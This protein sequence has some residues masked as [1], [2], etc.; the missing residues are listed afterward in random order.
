M[1]K[2]HILILLIF[3]IVHISSAMASTDLSVCDIHRTGDDLS[4][5]VLNNGSNTTARLTVYAAVENDALVESLHPYPAEGVHHCNETWNITHPGAVRMRIH[6]AEIGLFCGKRYEKNVDHLIIEDENGILVRDYHGSPVGRGADP[7]EYY[8]SDIYTPWVSGGVIRIILNIT[9]E[10]WDWHKTYGFRIDEYD[11]YESGVPIY[12]ED[13]NF[14]DHELK[15]ILFPA[16]SDYVV[17]IIDEENNINETNET[18]NE[19]TRK[20]APEI[21]E[22]EFD[23]A[24][25]MIGDTVTI[26]A[27]VRNPG[28]DATTKVL[29][30]IDDADVA[31]TTLSIAHNETG[32]AVFHWTATEG[33]HNITIVTGDDELDDMLCV[34]H[35]DLSV[36]N[37]TIEPEDPVMGNPATITTDGVGDILVYDRGTVP[38]HL[39]YQTSMPSSASHCWTLRHPGADWI[40]LH[41]SH[42]KLL[43]DTRLTISNGT[44]TESYGYYEAYTNN[45]TDILTP[46]IGGD[47]LYICLNTTHFANLTIDKYEYRANEPLPSNWSAYP[48]GPHNITAVVNENESIPELD[49]TNNRLSKEIIVEGCD[50][51]ITHIDITPE[52]S[53]RD[54]ETVEI[55]VTVRNIGVLPATSDVSFLVDNKHIDFRKITL[56]EGESTTLTTT[57]TA[58]ANT[59]EIRVVADAEDNVSETDE[60][61]NELISVVEVAGA[62][63]SVPA[64]TADPATISAT[65]R[66]TGT[67]SDARIDVY[68]CTF[69]ETYNSSYLGLIGDQV[70]T[71]SYTGVDCVCV[72]LSCVEPT[73]DVTG[74][75]GTVKIS[76][77][78]WVV[79]PGDTISLSGYID[80]DNPVHAEFYAGPVIASFDEAIGS[81]GS[82]DI[83]TDWAPA[84][85]NHAA[86]VYADPGQVVC[87]T[88]EENNFG[89]AYIY[90]EPTVDFAVT[91]PRISPEYLVDGDSANI[92]VLLNGTADGSLQFTLEDHLTRN[93]TEKWYGKSLTIAHES[94][95]IRVHFRNLS[96]PRST[97]LNITDASGALLFSHTY[98]DGYLPGN[99]SPWMYAETIRIVKVGGFSIVA[100]I[101]K[102]EC[103]NMLKNETVSV[104]A[105]TTREITDVWQASTGDHTI[106]AEITSGIEEIHATNDYADKLVSVKPSRDPAVLNITYDPPEPE[107]GDIML[108]NATIANTGFRQS[109]CSVEIWDTAERNFTIEANDF[110][111][112]YTRSWR[113]PGARTLTGIGAEMTGVHFESIDTAVSGDHSLY[114]YDASGAEIA[115]F[116]HCKRDDL[117]VWGKGDFL[118]VGFRCK[119]DTMMP[120]G[121]RID[122][123]AYRKLLN[124][125]M[126]SL[127]S[128]EIATV[129]A[130]LNATSGWHTIETIIDP[131]DQIDEINESNNVLREPIWVKG[132]DL[133]PVSIRSNSDGKISAVIRNI[134]DARAENVTVS[135]CRE[136]NYSY[137]RTRF[138]DTVTE[139]IKHSDA[140]R[141]RVRFKDMKI[142]GNLYIKDK[143]GVVVDEY[144]GKA[145]DIWTEWVHGDTVKIVA[146]VRCKVGVPL[147]SFE[148]DR[149]EYEFESETI[150][151][152]ADSETRAIG[153]TP[154][155][156][157]EP[158]N[159]SVWVDVDDTILESD[160]DNNNKRV[161]V[162][163]DLVADGIRFVSP[164]RYMLCLDA[165]KFTIDG[166]ITNGGVRDAGDTI[167][168]PVSDFNV[169]LEVRHLHSNGDVGDVLFNIT[170]YVGEPFYGGQHKIRFEFD[171][172]EKFE[173]GGDYTISLIAD[174]T[175]DVCESN[176]LYPEGEDNNVTSVDVH[177]YNTSGYTGG[178][179]LVNV[180]QGE[181]RGR[182]VYTVGDSRY[183]RKM[184]PGEE[185][186]VRY[187]EVITANADDIEFARIFVYWFAYHS[188]SG[189]SVPDLADVDVAF[190]GHTLS[191]AGNY[192]DNPGATWNDYGYGLYSYDVTDYITGGGNDVATVKNNNADA[193]ATMGVHAIGLLVAYDDGK[194]PLTKYWVN[195]GAD[196]M[197]AANGKYPT[198]LPSGDCV[199][200]A[201]FKGV[202][203]N[204]TEN[205]NAALLTI[206]G[207]HSAYS[208]DDLFSNP[209]DAYEFNNHPIGSVKGTSHWIK[210]D[211]IGYPIDFNKNKKWDSVTDYLKYGDNLV[212]ICSKG[213]YMMPGNAFLRL[214]F[215]PDLNVINLSAPESTV[216]GAQHSINTTIRNDGR[217]DAHDFNVTF[218]IDG[219]QMVRIPHLDLPA[220]ENM[221]LHLY[222]WTPM[223][224]VHVYNLTAAADVLS[225]EDWTEI[226]TDN[227]AMSKSVVMEEGGFGNQ[228]GPRGTGGGSNPTGGKFTEE[229]T[230]RVMQGMKESLSVGG[231][232]GAGMFSLT[233]W[234]MKGAV[235]LALLSFVCLGYRMEGRSYGRASWD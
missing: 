168:V 130:M 71:V 112:W 182:V 108:I 65:I 163:V 181:V 185:K 226:E 141:I 165:E 75:T 22:I 142:Y 51:S 232:G 206:L 25:P 118:T 147:S 101:D 228:T 215:P 34:C 120:E 113:I 19:L 235:W 231:G 234:I 90:I 84:A 208:P 148:I 46:E 107:N 223:M 43:G 203:R 11:T 126:V 149:Y 134:G 99:W 9:A 198:G 139:R 212:E 87:E 173:V 214:I 158:Y 49:F 116:S 114:I 106:H 40:R 220:G 109:D 94:D 30:R 157:E 102:Y 176:E 152:D 164:D 216:V 35:S 211:Y 56:A 6:L 196:I 17:A 199:T 189:R 26:S 88:D 117:W 207:M 204:D 54:G 179:D 104:V 28:T 190:N 194:G 16:D 159:L 48:A 225:G 197:M 121:F 64:I 20:L 124:H 191:K 61:N 97:Y 12:D 186:T 180:A 111:E 156:Y 200:I 57:W 170:E 45:F 128:G 202:E 230:G 69:K 162:Y 125:T 123:Y 177:V 150:D 129:H 105:N 37:L 224:L 167:V 8:L 193:Y 66:N 153:D 92:T 155:E 29:L 44:Y 131:E 7:A 140:T 127:D 201:S 166:C 76:D 93:L 83:S 178:G 27:G 10:R 14:G 122:R 169:T 222:N 72:N 60:T 41:F 213:N 47:T 86:V 209:G 195:E 138:C 136:V 91:T 184:K 172:K 42:L 1:D 151:L 96:T 144:S 24:I 53:M 218:Y 77:P 143:D 115:D 103:K 62:D 13:I 229:I 160:E 63:F 15:D 205:V 145:S 192:S 21:T 38:Y 52:E 33:C 81:N 175:G 98:D 187:T 85:G 233:E 183:G 2:Y 137:S 58:V 18:N 70:K 32:T 146:D 5:S 80:G 4:V 227:N 154:C 132:P 31:N 79:M 135:F 67:A 23:P 68:D 100:D 217:S 110:F 73:L 36:T 219:K 188:E 50:L 161:M 82:L 39:T 133:T 78:A 95:A 55:D 174:S 119:N 3:T 74:S 221:T 210:P 89:V 171:P 59:H